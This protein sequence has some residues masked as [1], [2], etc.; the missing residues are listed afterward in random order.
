M[1]RLY[2][3]FFI[4][5][6]FLCYIA[7]LCSLS[8]AL[9]ANSLFVRKYYSSHN[10]VSGFFERITDR[11]EPAD[12]LREPADYF[13]EPADY[14]R[15]PADYLR[16]PENYWQFTLNYER[17]ERIS[18]HRAVNNNENSDAA[19]FCLRIHRNTFG[20]CRRRLLKSEVRITKL[21]QS[22]IRYYFF[23][24]TLPIR[25]NHSGQPIDYTGFV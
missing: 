24:H 10:R 14:L 16:E 7:L 12:Y 20:R 5:F 13:R 25:L 17:F 19:R 11:R 1:Q 18:D 2:R 3:L 9:A 15:E 8:E 4:R 22:T 23:N 6:F 21:S